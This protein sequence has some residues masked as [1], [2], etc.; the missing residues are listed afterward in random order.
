LTGN[1]YRD[2]FVEAYYP[3]GQHNFN[4]QWTAGP[5]SN[6]FAFADVVLGLPREI[7]AGLDI[8]DPNYR[9]SHVMPW[10][11]DDWKITPRLTINLGLRYEWM[12]K[13]QANRD[14]I[15]NFYQTGPN[16]AEIITPRDTGLEGYFKKPDTLGRGLMMD[17]NNNFAPRVGFAYQASPKTVVRGAYGVFYQRDA[18]C[19]WIGMALNPPFVRNG[20]VVLSVNEQSY[21][22]Y[23]IED[24]TT[25]VN[26]RSTAK[27]AMTGMAVDW[28][29]AYVQQWNAFIERQVGTN[30]VVNV[31]Y[32]AHHA[33]GLQRALYPNEPAPAAGNVQLQRPFQ[34][35]ASV[36]VRSPSGQST[37]NGLEVKGQKRFSGGLSM[38]GS[39]TWSRTIDDLRALD[40]WYLASWKQLS[41]LNIG[42][43]FSFSGVYEIPFGRGRR[44]GSHTTA[45]SNAVLGGWQMSAI[46]VL[47]SGFPFTV[48]TAGNIA[49]TGGITQVPIRISDPNLARSVRTEDRFFDTSAFVAP[50]AFT[51]GNA[52]GNPLVGPG[53]Q[54]VDMSLGKVFRLRERF[55]AHFRGEFFN[56]LN[57][58]N[59]G[60]PGATLGTA[61]FGRITSTTG[62]PRTLQFGL[63][64]LY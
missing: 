58:P 3:A 62:E 36:T 54:N 47:R 50:A 33:V 16:S 15:S 59:Q 51:L 7:L 34:T 63:K 53:F 57:H 41:D 64:L 52:G 42:H 43:R 20:D 46:A 30:T 35:L 28:H 45:L 49:N 19:T 12:G 17:D 22:D 60:Q 31:G 48:T 1:R 5:G 14:T 37:Y 26:Y 24:L 6:G 2:T 11:Q 38:L 32:V 40:L 21:H 13:P 39:Y 9:N 61:T 23:P 27:P 10:V 44:F 55:T 25:V 29:E 8:F 18:A 56:I 4:G